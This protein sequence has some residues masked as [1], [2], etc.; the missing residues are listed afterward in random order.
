MQF[1]LSLISIACLLAAFILLRQARA[2]ERENVKLQKRVAL[3]EKANTEL[4][5][6]NDAHF[7]Q[8]AGAKIAESIIKTEDWE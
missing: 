3:L 4:R 6:E 8:E 2:V 7:R 5:E 1:V